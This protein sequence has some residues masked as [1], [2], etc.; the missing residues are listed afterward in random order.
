M[1]AGNLVDVIFSDP[2]PTPMATVESQTIIDIDRHYFQP[3]LEGMERI[4]SYNAFRG[5]KVADFLRKH[6]MSL[7]KD[8]AIIRFRFGREYS[9]VLYINVARSIDG[10]HL[11][12][13]ERETL[14]LALIEE[15]KQT[16]HPDEA[17]IQS[18]GVI[19]LWWD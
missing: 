2:M 7:N 6:L 10:G 9:P 5:K 17:D 14:A 15:A 8:G 11:T 19:R 4:S 1:N 13:E 12:P 16:I 3:I 18:E